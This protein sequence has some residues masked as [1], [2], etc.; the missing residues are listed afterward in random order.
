MQDLHG[1]YFMIYYNI[2]KSSYWLKDL[3]KGP[4]VFIKLDYPL[5]MKDGM[6]IS[7]GNSFLQ[8]IFK[9]KVSSNPEVE[10][11]KLGDDNYRV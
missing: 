10:I 11:R 1:R 9:T 4:G 7:I 6:I 8:F 2:D 5:V 3:G